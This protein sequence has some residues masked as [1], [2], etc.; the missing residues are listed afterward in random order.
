M[1][2]IVITGGLGYIGMELSKIYS[3]KSRTN[4]I[5]VLD[6][7]FYSSRVSQLSRWGIKYE[8]CDILDIENLKKHIV[9]ADIIFH[10]AGITNVPTTLEQEKLSKNSMIR[11]TG[12]VGTRNII[13]YSKDN[14]KIIFPSTHV[15]FEGIQSV[16]RNITEKQKPKPILEYSKGKYQSELDLINSEKDFVILR[17][18]SLYGRSFDSTRLNIMPNLF[19]KMSAT[20]KTLKL[21]SKGKQLKSLVSV[22]DVARAME[23]VE[24]NKNCSREIYNLV[25][26]NLTVADVAKICKKHN[27]KTNIQTFI[28]NKMIL[29][30]DR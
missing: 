24:V 21:F 7:E 10:L 20:G 30:K 3:G 11:K 25:N 1:Q 4:E 27:K 9:D 14:V 8:Q 18:G 22:V 17:L 23:F 13:N 28:Q 15:I 6:K 26:E 5:I 29:Q 12:V 2:K 16:K 19:A